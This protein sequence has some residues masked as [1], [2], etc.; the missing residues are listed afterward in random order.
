MQEALQDLDRVKDLSPNDKV[1]IQDRECLN[2]LASCSN[3]KAE[4]TEQSD[5]PPKIDRSTFQK[6]AQNLSKLISYENNENMSKLIHESS[7][8]HHHSMIIPSANRTKMDKIR[9]IKRR[10][11]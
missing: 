11:E 9:A 1:A 4:P 5:S 3:L 2:S 8:S 6:A 10:K 7:I